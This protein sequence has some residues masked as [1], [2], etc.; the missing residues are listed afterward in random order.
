MVT[1]VINIYVTIS[2]TTF[3]Q[4]A[5]EYSE[6][7][8]ELKVRFTDIPILL[9]HITMTTQNITRGLRKHKVIDTE[10]EQQK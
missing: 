9:Y 4:S 3:T 5:E 7:P 8:L 10:K 6:A 2:F 1:T